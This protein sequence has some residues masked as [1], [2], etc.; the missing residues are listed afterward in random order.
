MTEGDVILACERA[1][2]I[3]PDGVAVVKVTTP[4]AVTLLSSESMCYAYCIPDATA[5]DTLV[6]LPTREKGCRA[7]F[8]ALQGSAHLIDRIEII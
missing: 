1:C 3:Y 2:L 5:K 6:Y 4:Y 8:E 7:L